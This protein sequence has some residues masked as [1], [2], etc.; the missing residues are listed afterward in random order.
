MAC[1]LGLFRALERIFRGGMLMTQGGIPRPMP[2]DRRIV[3]GP[4]LDPNAVDTREMEPATNGADA[5]I[6]RVQSPIGQR[7]PRL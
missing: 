3:K 1:L 4:T 2:P 5:D 7:R 6:H